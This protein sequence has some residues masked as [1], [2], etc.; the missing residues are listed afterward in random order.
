MW[1]SVV[2]VCVLRS[3]GTRA[4]SFIGMWDL[5]R[6]G[7]EPISSALAG[8]FLTTGPPGKYSSPFF[9]FLVMNSKFFFFGYHCMTYL[10][11][12]LL[13]LYSYNAFCFEIFL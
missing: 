1:V 6:P 8:R 3:C 11:R 2:V 4:Y 5:P 10:L 13:C 12:L 7:I 9:F